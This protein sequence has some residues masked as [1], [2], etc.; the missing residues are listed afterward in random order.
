MMIHATIMWPE[1]EDKS[2]WPLAINHAAHLYNHTPN[3]DLGGVAPIE[4]FTGA[5]NDGQA[6]KQAHPWGCPVYVL[7]PRLTSDGGKIPKWQPRSRRGQYVGVSPLHAENISLIRNLTTGHLSPQYHLV[8]DDWFE[9]VYSSAEQPPPQWEFMCAFQR[10]EV[11]FDEGVNPPPLSHEWLTPEEIVADQVRAHRQQLRQGRQLYQGVKSKDLRDD[12]HF[13]AP[14][15]STPP[16]FQEQPLHHGPSTATTSNWNREPTSMP[17]SAP[18]REPPPSANREPPSSPG[19]TSPSPPTHSENFPA[20]T[21][22]PPRRISSRTSKGHRDILNIGDTSGQSYD[23]HKVSHGRP[24]SL[25]ACGLMCAFGITPMSSHLMHN[26]VL[27]FNPVSHTMESF[28][29]AITQSVLAMKATAR[30]D[31]DLPTLQESLTGPHAEHFWK[32]MDKEIASLEGMKTWDVVDRSS[33][34]SGMKVVPG[35]WAQ[36]I[37]RLPDGSLNKFKSRWCCRGDLQDYTGDAYSPLVGWP[38]V[39]AGLLLAAAHGWKS[40]QVD[41]TL[42]FCQTPLEDDDPLY[43][44]LPQYYR[45][46]G[47]EGRDVVLKMN[48]SIYG[49]RDSPKLFY[50]YLCKGMAKLGFVQSKADPCLFVHKKLKIMVLNYC[51][52]QIWLSPDN[53]L[54][55]EYVGKLKGLG[56]DLTLEEDGDIFGFLGINMKKDGSNIILTQEGL[57]AKV[58]AYLGLSNASPK[59]TPAASDP[60]GSDKSGAPFEEEWSYPAAVGMLLYLASNTR[61]DLT[62]AVHQAARFSH[63][64]KHSHAQ[65]VKRIGRYLV[66]TKDKG[67]IFCPDLEQGLDCY[68]DADFAGMYGYEDEQDPVSVKSRTGF[69][70]TLFNCPIVWSSKLQTE[71]TLSSTAAEY[72]AFSMAMRELLPMRALIGELGELLNMPVLTTS[73]VRSTVFEDNQGCLSLV[74][75]PKMSARNKYLA[76]KY[77]FFRSNIGEAKGIVAKYISTTEQ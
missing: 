46:A 20:P 8:H 57:T 5:Q 6:L 50:E 55:E 21:P 14:S 59:S 69:V 32:A 27:G 29:P 17:P 61:P 28:Q 75:V 24:S 31:P 72:V 76:L 44:E 30:R 74:N 13:K 47:T 15:N 10:F 35:T 33:V 41:F 37:K 42:A 22:A 66:G 26:Q 56:Y 45:P 60:L 52:D 40:R 71:I 39:R 49:R 25:L 51:D 43:M 53:D 36:R 63:C 9:T 70:L 77:H 67:L 65:A 62:F 64:P 19:S 16:S 54:I 23:K 11:E 38:T 34:P 4:L 18:N 48:K 58:I 73:L 12:L 1:V 3:A 2:L 7:D 68:V